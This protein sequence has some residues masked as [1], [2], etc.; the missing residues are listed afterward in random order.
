M[1]VTQLLPPGLSSCEEQSDLAINC[2]LISTHVAKP[3]SVGTLVESFPVAWGAVDA[4]QG[5]SVCLACTRLKPSINMRE[6]ETQR[7]RHRDRQRQKETERQ[8]D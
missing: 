5:W 8:R 4:V 1:C 2:I 7:Q 6:R 3:S